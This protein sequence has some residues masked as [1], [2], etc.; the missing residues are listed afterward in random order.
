MAAPNVPK[1]K[2][3]RFRPK[4]LR[5][6]AYRYEGRDSVNI[7][8]IGFFGCRVW[9]ACAAS[10]LISL[11]LFAF[12]A[13]PQTSSGARTVPA[14]EVFLKAFYALDE[15]RFHCVDIP[16]HRSRVNV[17]RALV[18]HTCKE[19]IWHRDEIFNQSA[20]SKGQL[21]MSEYGLCVSA[22]SSSDG[23]KLIL[24]E[25]DNS[26]LQSWIFTNY[27]LKL[28]RYPD[29]CLTIG[30]EPSKLTPGGR[31]LASRNMSRSL[32][33]STC[34]EE[35]FRRQLWRMEPPLERSSP[36]LP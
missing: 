16:G 19:G 35:A 20:I 14:K 24:R 9:M 4:R 33:L 3:P 22:G 13:E 7:R 11:S 26:T 32:M 17:A 12:D 1:A 21:K 18:V 36:I 34:S 6:F 31:R 2:L 29:K 15:P 27:R 30:P 8:P 23:A 25:C 5:V 10:L 28:K